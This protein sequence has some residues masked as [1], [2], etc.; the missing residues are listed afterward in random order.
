MHLMI[1]YFI[2][3]LHNGKDPNGLVSHDYNN[4]ITYFIY[5]SQSGTD[6][7]GLVYRAGRW[8]DYDCGDDS[9][10][11]VCQKNKE[12]VPTSDV[13]PPQFNCPEGW[14]WT[15]SYCLFVTE[16]LLTWEDAQQT[17]LKEDTNLATVRN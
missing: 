8:G 9:F 10:G 1:S 5:L 13:P 2:D 12:V 16:D 14:L 6:P 11:Y 15:S 4:N 3:L 7:S 17:C